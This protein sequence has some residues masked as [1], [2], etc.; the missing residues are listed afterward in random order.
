MVLK[1]DLIHC[2]RS[3]SEEAEEH[4]LEEKGE[5]VPGTRS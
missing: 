3:L 1:Q 5:F 4:G 2:Q